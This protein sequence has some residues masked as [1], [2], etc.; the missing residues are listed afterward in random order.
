MPQDPVTGDPQAMPVDPYGGVGMSGSG[1]PMGDPYASG[2]MGPGGGQPS[3]GS[4][5]AQGGM[6]PYADPYGPFAGSPMPQMDPAM[7]AAM[8][9]AGQ[10]GPYG[11]PQATP[12]DPSTVF[13]GS[14]GAVTPNPAGG[15]DFMGLHIPSGDEL[16]NSLMQK[17][18]PELTTDQLP[19]LEARYKQETAD[20]SK[21]RARR[22]EKAFAEYDRQLEEYM[23]GLRTKLHAHQRIAMSSAELGARAEEE[24]A[25]TAI[26]SSIAKMPDPHAS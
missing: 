24:D 13:G 25:L 16:Y 2:G 3:M 5:Y 1:F 15:M 14:P 20:Q 22:Y 26:E 11:P 19:Q 21:E 9:G 17:I 7:M 8:Y 23:S 4:P 10:P 12:L 6:S 18:E